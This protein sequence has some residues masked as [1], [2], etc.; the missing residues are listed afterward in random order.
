MRGEMVDERGRGVIQQVRVVHDEGRSGFTGV[1]EAAGEPAQDGQPATAEVG[2]LGQ[3][4]R[5]RPELDGGPRPGRGHPLRRRAEAGLR[6]PRQPGS[7]QAAGPH[8]RDAVAA[9]PVC[10]QD[11]RQLAFAVQQRPGV[12][13]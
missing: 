6:L 2:V 3:E 10:A 1:V 13:C 7:A 9:L 4:M 8:E 5:E 11:L 12:L